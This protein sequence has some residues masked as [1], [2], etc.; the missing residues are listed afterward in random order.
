MKPK[1]KNQDDVV[2]NRAA[3]TTCV[4]KGRNLYKAYHTY[5]H[6]KKGRVSNLIRV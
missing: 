1:N 3:P 2:S 6:I 5:A 4:D